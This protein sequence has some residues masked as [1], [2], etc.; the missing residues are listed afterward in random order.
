ME[1]KYPLTDKE[2]D[3]LSALKIG[4]RNQQA[5]S[6]LMKLWVAHEQMMRCELIQ[7]LGSEVVKFAAL[8]SKTYTM[9]DVNRFGKHSPFLARSLN[10]SVRHRL[11]KEALFLAKMIESTIDVV[12]E[13]KA[14]IKECRVSKSGRHPSSGSDSP[15]DHCAIQE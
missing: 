3:Y 10:I 4:G 11:M 13:W 12:E 7:M 14:D 6:G 1:V 2:P 15:C 5:S 9:I 8:C